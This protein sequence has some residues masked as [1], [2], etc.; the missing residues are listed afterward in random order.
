M[1]VV[2]LTCFFLTMITLSIFYLVRIEVVHKIE[3]RALSLISQQAKRMI[4]AGN[5]NWEP[6]YKLLDKESFT[7]KVLSITKWRLQDFY[8]ELVLEEWQSG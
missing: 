7:S 4:D 2:V 8:P 1:A 3:M 6:L 5:F